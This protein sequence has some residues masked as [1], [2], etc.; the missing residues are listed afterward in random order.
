M[1]RLLQLAALFQAL[2]AS[3]LLVRVGEVSTVETPTFPELVAQPAVLPVSPPPQRVKVSPSI[4]KGITSADLFDPER[5]DR[6]P[7]EVAVDDITFDEPP[8]PPPTTITL[9]GILVLGDEP[10]AIMMDA[11]QG[12]D[13]RR[14]RIGD[15]IGDYEVGEISA[16]S[17]ELIGN[18]PGEV[19][20]VGL[21]IAAG[22]GAVATVAAA[23]K[24]A[25]NT[26]AKT[27]AQKAAEARKRA[28]LAKA[29]NNKQQAPAAQN[30]N[31]SARER[32]QAAQKAR[33]AQKAGGAG[34][35]DDGGGD[36]TPKRDPVQLRLEALQRLREA[37]TKR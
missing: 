16:T 35:D 26:A 22:T 18:T 21:T 32:A 33:A 37:A 25:T 34:G 6:P 10:E 3:F 31:M 12:T 13:P 24:A 8:L 28:A 4:L 11:A 20:N 30:K 29:G 2:L 7:E 36:G 5:G 15:M 14:V 19:F 9:S 27:A 1:K 23:L 17:V